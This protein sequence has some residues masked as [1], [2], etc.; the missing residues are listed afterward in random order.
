MTDLLPIRDAQEKIIAFA[1]PKRIEMC[2]VDLAYHRILAADIRSPLSL[3]AFNNS[4]MDGFAVN[5]KDVS[6]AS[7]G[8][9][10]TLPVSVDIPAG[11]TQKV[12]LTPGTAARILTGAPIPDGAD[13][14][15][16]VEDTDHYRQPQTGPL[17]KTVAFFKSARP[18]ENIRPVGEDVQTGQ[19][20]LQ[21]GR[22]LLPQDIGLLVSL[23][24]Q[25][26]EVLQ[27]PRIA[28]FSSGDELLTPDQPLSPGKIYD[29]NRYVLTGLLEEAGA[30]VI[31]LGIARD[32]PQSVEET[33][34]QALENPPDLIISS[35]GVSVGAFDFVREVIEARGSLSFWRV[36]M[37]PGKPIAFGHYQNIPFIGLPGNPVSA[38][39]GTLVFVLPFIRQLRGR[40][41]FIPNMIKV[42]LE[43]PLY[44]ADGRE[45]FY[46][47]LV[48]K[49]NDV[50]K[51]RLTGH[52]GS[53]NLFS[54]VQANALL[55]VP[56]GVKLIP[57][58][59]IINAWSLDPDLS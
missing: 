47:G 52:Q 25:E 57:A 4:S 38:Y 35:A 17:Q 27:K 31:Q 18:G 6:G 39:I 33:L 2:K 29:S 41:P 12:T 7:A 20:V 19:I 56:A 54:L 43:E 24:I 58:G 51:A 40:P 13:T 37:R 8:S 3:P 44:S 26:V 16:P 36:N 55:I 10:V 14:V 5:S 53:G 32:N 21:K 49:E 59:E 9:P 15:I 46:R 22:C 1:K 30:E 23:G 42:V 45:S 11:L 50:F 48:H 28:L 34:D